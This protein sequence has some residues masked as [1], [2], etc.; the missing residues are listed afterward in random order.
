VNRLAQ[1]S[2]PYL[3]QHRD[4]PVDWHPWGDEAFAEA[5]SRDV[6]V[7]LSVGYSACHWCHVMA[8]ESFEDVAT[9]TVMNELFVNVKVDREE[10][11]DVDAVY[12]EALQSMTGGGGWPMTVFL[13][14]DGRPFHAGTYFPPRATRGM[15][16]FADVLRAVDEAWRERRPAL[17]EHAGELTASLGRPV[18][19]GSD[20]SPRPGT[21]A[22][23]EAANAIAAR[24]DTTWG[25]FGGPPKFPQ[26]M[27]IELLLR[28]HDRT[29]DANLLAAARLS[30]DAMAAGGVDDHLG[31]GFARYS[32]DDRWLVPH[33]EKMLY[34]QALLARTYLH[35]WQVTAEPAYRQVLDET[36]D[37]VLR[38]LRSPGGG[39]CSAEDADSEGVEG[40]F[41]VWSLAEV[42]EVAGPE[43][44]AWWGVTE[45]GNFES[46]NI[47]FRPVG[48]PLL[49]PPA[50][51]A[52]RRALFERRE[53][54]VRPGL[55]DKVLAEWNG[56]FLASLAEAAA[57]TGNAPWLAAAEEIGRFL[58]A[59]LLVDGRWRRSWQADTG[60]RHLAVAADHAALVDAFTRLAEATGRAVWLEHA[61]ATA[62]ALLE[63]FRD[64]ADGCLFTT[65]H[66]AERLVA[67]QKDLL[68]GA[69]PSANSMAAVALARLGALTAD[70]RYRE[71][72]E[73][74]LGRLGDLAVKH[75][76]AFAHLLAAADLG[77]DAQEVVVTGDRPDLVAAVQA[78]YLPRTVLA[79]GDRTDSPLW[80]DRPH[81]DDPTA[82]R[83]YVC[84]GYTCQL[85]V[86]TVDGLV[87]QLGP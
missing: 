49:R 47:L 72:S 86:D 44:A 62:D 37:Y 9:A 2:S 6:P 64:D 23:V 22:V 53:S 1:E 39:L 33:F 34:D 79:W 66:D 16:G 36:V 69:T 20:T 31:G 77:H 73:T 18:S 61:R 28:A 60:A 71:A 84:E 42:L 80:T 7:L 24:L 58:V 35:A 51:E 38:E 30:L 65:G 81:P 74:I 87:D 56:L 46:A 8:H 25:G 4:N 50:I 43:A 82:G 41:Y 63:L 5:R 70:A 67:R 10:R 21:E 11:P 75:P 32:V 55:D 40:K 83:V 45:H 29:G 78:R 3:R 85:P 76:M 48:A 59:E 26:T 19:T 27:S 54:R 13:D 12:M 15:P 17:L 57:A 68:D 14:H 52:A